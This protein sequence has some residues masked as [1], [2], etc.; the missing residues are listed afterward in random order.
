[1]RCDNCRKDIAIGLFEVQS[2]QGEFAR[3]L[4]LC[5]KCLLVL[6]HSGYTCHLLQDYSQDEQDKQVKNK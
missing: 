3:E 1:M 2:F 4:K 5:L 6:D